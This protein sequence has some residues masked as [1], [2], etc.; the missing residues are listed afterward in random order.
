[1][2]KKSWGLLWTNVNNGY[3]HFISNLSSHIFYMCLKM[4]LWVYFN[5]NNAALA[6]QAI[7]IASRWLFSFFFYQRLT[8]SV[9]KMSAI[10]PYAPIWNIFRLM[11]WLFYK[12]ILKYKVLQ[13]SYWLNNMKYSHIITVAL[14]WIC[15]KSIV[16]SAMNDLIR[17]LCSTK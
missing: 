1:M 15:R 11:C 9:T 14:L 7:S 2:I 6:W 8:S 10:C 13:Q 16:S 17:L 4:H 5:T 12:R 3:T